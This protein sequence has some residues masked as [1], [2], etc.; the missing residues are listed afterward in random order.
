MFIKFSVIKNDMKNQSYSMK[1]IIL[2]IYN[3]S[4]INISLRNRMHIFLS[5]TCS[6]VWLSDFSFW[7]QSIFSDEKRRMR[8]KTAAGGDERGFPPHGQPIRNDINTSRHSA[9][10]RAAFHFAFARKPVGV[11]VRARYLPFMH[12]LVKRAG[13]RKEWIIKCLSCWRRWMKP[14]WSTWPWSGAARAPVY[15]AT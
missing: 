1:S 11:P 6:S 13:L 8:W 2:Y 5:W 12:A 3:I 15:G 9:R 4:A 10:A 7:G 14:S